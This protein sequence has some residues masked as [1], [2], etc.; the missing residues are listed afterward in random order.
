MQKT[1]P[2]PADNP[3]S[4]HPELL[5]AFI[6]AI[7]EE[8]SDFGV[9]EQI[10]AQPDDGADAEAHRYRTRLAHESKINN[11]WHVTARVS[12]IPTDQSSAK[13]WLSSPDE[14]YLVSGMA[15]ISTAT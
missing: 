1:Q 10:V 4:H 9:M 7:E 3:Q 2:L 15:S 8:A 6:K 12:P 13:P 14:D 11:A 5:D